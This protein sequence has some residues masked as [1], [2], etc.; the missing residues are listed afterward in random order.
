MTEIELKDLQVQDEVSGGEIKVA[1]EQTGG[2]GGLGYEMVLQIVKENAVTQEQDPT[3]PDW[4]KQPEKPTY[5]YDEITDKPALFSGNYNDL[6]NKPTIPS[7][8]GL[9]TESYVNNASAQAVAQGISSHNVDQTAHKDIRNLISELSNRLNAIADSDDTTLDQLSEIV[10]YI[11]ANKALIES[12]TT[13]KVNVSDIINDLETNVANKPLSASQGVALKA[14]ISTLE[15]S[16]NDLEENAVSDIGS[17]VAEET[18]EL[19]I[20]LKD[21]NGKVIATTKVTLPTQEIPEVDLSA[22]VKSADRD[23][24]VIGGLTENSQTLSSEQRTSA[25]DFIG[26]F[27]A[28]KP[29][30]AYTSY[31]P[32]F[33]KDEKNVVSHS[34]MTISEFSLKKD[35]SGYVKTVTGT[36]IVYGTDHEKNQTTVGYHNGIL[37]NC[38][39]QRN[40]DGSV[41][42]PTL[43]DKSGDVH[44]VNYVSM[45]TYVNNLPDKITLTDEEKAKWRGMIGATKW[46][47]HADYIEINSDDDGGDIMYLEFLSNGNSQQSFF[48]DKVILSGRTASAFGQDWIV[49][50]ISDDRTVMF[51]MD[52]YENRRIAID[53]I[54]VDEHHVTEL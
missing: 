15:K 50:G 36:K 54:T 44:A 51:L 27:P 25:C 37:G 20:E 26:A 13:S 21:K 2:G 49:L 23:S 7:I 48:E 14:L 6:T 5:S 8:T 52:C 22:Y 30:I 28:L 19:T 41:Q 38:L 31:V 34:S 17:E 46:Y 45:R 9:A 12:V 40:P 32:L 43:T 11:K 24:F 16:V 35:L 10:A 1:V 33:S 39:V 3:V 18:N 47:Y 42:V 4:A 53:L 29:D